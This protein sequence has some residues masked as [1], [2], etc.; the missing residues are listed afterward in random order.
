MDREKLIA[1]SNSS[2]RSNSP[3]IIGGAAGGSALVLIVFALLCIR[4]WRKRGR[5]HGVLLQE[6]Q[7]S[8]ND[9]SVSSVVEDV[10]TTPP[11]IQTTSSTR[12][13]QTFKF[14]V[15]ENALKLSD[16]GVSSQWFPTVSN[17]NIVFTSSRTSGS[18][19]SM[20]SDA[21]IFNISRGGVLRI[22]YTLKD[23]E[24]FA[25]AH[26][27]SPDG[28]RLVRW[29]KS[30]PTAANC[31]IEAADISGT[32]LIER[33]TS[34]AQ[35]DM[36]DIRAS[37][38]VNSKTIYIP[39][40]GNKNII[41][42]SLESDEFHSRTFQ[43]DTSITRHQSLQFCVT[44]DEKWWVVIGRTPGSQGGGTGLIQIHNVEDETDEFAAGVACYIAEVEV[45]DVKRALLVVADLN[46]G[47][48]VLR[49]SQLDPSAGGEAFNPVE[50]YKDL[51]DHG[52]YPQL[53]IVFQSLPII[54]VSTARNALYFFELHFG[55]FLFY[56]HLEADEVC[57]G[58]ADGQSLII[59]AI[60]R[61]CIDCVAVNKNDLIG[62][63]RH[64]L[65]LDMLAS[66]IAIRSHLPG[67]EDIILNDMHGVFGT[68]RL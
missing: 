49:V 55:S 6:R 40:S 67:A 46:D 65:K 38:W 30:G 11:L 25:I 52:D 43:P 17:Q 18:G 12:N 4:W 2:E 44:E 32:K 22:S 7:Q 54:A 51:L 33:L 35:C 5:R 48:L 64:V 53:V 59:H 45:Y 62:Y 21:V 1:V 8:T 63:V 9:L 66:A 31:I 34:E 13:P 10:A 23:P 20:V 42:W 37:K 56:Q 58:S 68:L 61:D 14:L 57:Y 19:R 41:R 24:H 60:Q 16:T 27:L 3:A 28:E 50:T 36:I 29:S 47:K 39:D 26:V 15:S